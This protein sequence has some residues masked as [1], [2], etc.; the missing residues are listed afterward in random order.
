MPCL[1]VLIS[2]TANADHFDRP[3]PS[4]PHFPWSPFLRS[5][6]F[7]SV[8]PTTT[9][10]SANQAENPELT[11]TGNPAEPAPAI[12]AT[13]TEI[14]ELQPGHIDFIS[15]IWPEILERAAALPAI[16][17]H[18]VRGAVSEDLGAWH[19]YNRLEDLHDYINDRLNH[20]P[21]LSDD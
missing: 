18:I 3:V 10:L 11:E 12:T 1:T 20:R 5:S 8:E 4:S 21:P 2:P 15:E 9:E 16:W 7:G 19:F 17:G 13:R 14:A 6:A